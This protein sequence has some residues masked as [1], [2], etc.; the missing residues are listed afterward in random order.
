VISL[1]KEDSL[2]LF[3]NVKEAKK[4][5]ARWHHQDLVR[6]ARVE[7]YSINEKLYWRSNSC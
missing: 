2:P 1:Q 5:S 3:A 7:Y 4:L 6:F